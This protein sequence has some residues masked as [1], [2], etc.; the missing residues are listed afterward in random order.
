MSWMNKNGTT[1]WIDEPVD[2]LAARLSVEKL[3]R[4]LI[5]DLADEGLETYLKKKL[6]EREEFYKQATY[7]LS[8]ND[9]DENGFAKI[10][11]Q[12]V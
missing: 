11:K 5:K 7:R 1:I 9:L 10:I 8:G 12:Y 4:P 2:V 3:N 6:A